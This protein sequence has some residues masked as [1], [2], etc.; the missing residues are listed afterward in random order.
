LACEAHLHRRLAA[1]SELPEFVPDKELDGC[2]M[3]DRTGGDFAPVEK[4]L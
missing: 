1:Q 3:I 2:Q 4:H